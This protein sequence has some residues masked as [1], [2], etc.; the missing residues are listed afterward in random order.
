MYDAVS[1]G[2]SPCTT[3]S[4]LGKSR[5]RAATSVAKSTMA[6][7]SQNSWNTVMRFCCFILPCR[8]RRGT[9]GRSFRNASCMYWTCLQ[10][11]R[12]MSTLHLRCA[13]MKDHITSFFSW[14]SHTV[15]D[16]CS[17]CGVLCAASACTD[18]YSGSTRLMR[19]RSLMDLVCVAEK[20][21]VCRSV[22]RFSRMAFIVSEKPMSRQR[23]ASSRTRTLIWVQSKLG[24]SSMCWRS[25]PGVQMRMFIA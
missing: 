22:G 12:K 25:R 7:A 19:A 24:V 10:V 20:R 16:C 23:S 18:M 9:P 8:R 2:Q 21:R 3:H 1:S 14:S 4:T 17:R 11:E 6:S 5:P 13:L 15:Y